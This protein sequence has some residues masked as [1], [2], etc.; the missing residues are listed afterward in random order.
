[1]DAI[2]DKI[3]QD[4][5]ELVVSYQGEN[6]TQR[7]MSEFNHAIFLI[8]PDEIRIKDMEQST[9]FREEMMNVFDEQDPT[10]PGTPYL[11]QLEDQDSCYAARNC[12]FEFGQTLHQ[13]SSCEKN[14]VCE[15]HKNSICMLCLAVRNTTQINKKSLN[16]KD[17]REAKLEAIGDHKEN[18]DNKKATNDAGEAENK[19]EK[20]DDEE[21]GEGEGEDIGVTKDEEMDNREIDM[22]RRGEGVSD[23]HMSTTVGDG[24][25]E[26][27]EGIRNMDTG[28]Q[29][30]YDGNG[31]TIHKSTGET[32]DMISKEKEHARTAKFQ[33]ENIQNLSM[34]D[35]RFEREN[36]ITEL[37]VCQVRTR[38]GELIWV[39]VEDYIYLK[40]AHVRNEANSDGD[41]S[42]GSGFG[43]KN[44]ENADIGK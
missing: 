28:D 22:G 10:K 11:G 40:N 13:C 26:E 42:E 43:W 9:E 20:E 12:K 18:G 25:E 16:G 7:L 3:R 2:V 35:F 15:K 27:E 6:V 31:V 23:K 38:S 30:T 5:I 17:E 24:G 36:F 41:E 33:V 34:D 32:H 21:E 29:G 39:L 4:L 44:R 8:I 1:M 14:F 37:Q 19:E